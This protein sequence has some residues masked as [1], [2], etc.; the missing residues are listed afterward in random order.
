MSVFYLNENKNLTV[1]LKDVNVVVEYIKPQYAIGS[2]KIVGYDEIKVCGNCGKIITNDNHKYCTECGTK[3]REEVSSS[4]NT[5]KGDNMIN[6]IKDLTDEQFNKLIDKE[7]F[8]IETERKE[9]YNENE[10]KYTTEEI[11]NI[12]NELIGILNIKESKEF[13]FK[14]G[15]RKYENEKVYYHMLLKTI[16]ESDEVIDKEIIITEYY[17]NDSVGTDLG[18]WESEVIIG[19]DIQY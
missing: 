12:I 13:V 19:Y 14:Y 1:E 4:Q 17:Y 5:F 10:V 8:F 15:H 11:I 6:V 2:D 16:K 3:I 7:V 18:A 9:V